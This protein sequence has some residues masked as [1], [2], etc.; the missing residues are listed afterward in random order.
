[1]KMKLLAMMLLLGSMSACT[2]VEL[3]PEAAD[4]V[5][6]ATL[7]D[8]ES[9]K[10]LGKATVAVIDGVWFYTRKESLVSSELELLGMN[11][12]AEM[13][14]DTIVPMSKIVEGERVYNVY[15]CK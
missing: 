2:W 4:G 6:V 15:R 1:M 10:Q 13:G 9:C 8:V 3:T 7:S 12:A 14:G 5:S 11:S